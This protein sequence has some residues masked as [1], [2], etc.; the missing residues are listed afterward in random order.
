MNELGVVL[1]FLGIH[2][3][4]FFSFGTLLLLFSCFGCTE[5]QQK[6]KSEVKIKSNG[7][8]QTYKDDNRKVEKKSLQDTTQNAHTSTS[9]CIYVYIGARVNACF[10]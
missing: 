7:I 6:K 3:I 1:H 8:V 10:S 5:Q 4:N 9:Q 2:L